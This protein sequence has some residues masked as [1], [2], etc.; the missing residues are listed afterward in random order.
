MRAAGRWMATADRTADGAWRACGPAL[1]PAPADLVDALVAAGRDGPVL[2]A[3]DC[4]IGVPARFGEASGFGGFAALL[5]ALGRGEWPDLFAVAVTPGEVGPRRPFYPAR[6]GGARLRHLLDGHGV[7]TVDALVRACE[8]AGPEGGAAGCMFWTLGAKQVGKAALFAWREVVIPAR[9]RGAHLWPY[10]GDLAALAGRGGLVL[11]ESYPGDAYG[12]LGFKIRNK[13]DRAL[14]AALAPHLLGWAAARR[15]GLAD[16][17]AA[18]IRDGF[19]AGAGG[20][21]GFDAAMGLLA[22]IAVVDGERPAGPPLT[23]PSQRW[24]GWILG[25]RASPDPGPG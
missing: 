8:R 2:A 5:D 18:A 17:L 23:G 20:D 4:P 11:A 1:V 12:Q 10:D 15:V 22:A 9:R 19:P 14:R 24:E 3:F 25:K 7:D 21:D 16:D 13:R 6:P